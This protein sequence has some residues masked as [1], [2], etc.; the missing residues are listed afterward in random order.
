MKRMIKPVCA[1][2]AIN[3]KLCKQLGLYVEVEQRD[4]GTIPHMHVYHDK[5]RNPQKCSYI[6]L[7][8]AAYSK[9]HEV[10][11]LSKKQKELFLQIM[12]QP[13]SS[14]LVDASGKAT[15][16]TGYQYVVYTWVNT[17]CDDSY[18]GFTLDENGLPIMPDYKTYL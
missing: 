10:H 4:E 1:M 15:F 8:K 5:S 6:C 12:Q 2:S 14:A 13:C 7:D 11:K 3:A 16:G 9:H 18:E 17:Y